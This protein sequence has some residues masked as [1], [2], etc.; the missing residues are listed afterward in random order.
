MADAVAQLPE[1]FVLDVAPPTGLPEGFILD[2]PVDGGTPEGFVVDTPVVEETERPGF[3]ERVSTDIEARQK[4]GDEI[5][6]F[7]ERGEQSYPETLLQLTGKVGVGGVLDTMGEA[8][9]S[10]VEG[11]SA[12]TP[13]IIEDPLID[14]VTETAQSFMET[15][16]GQAGLEAFEA[17][18]EAW[19]A[20]KAENPR[21]ARN[22]EAG[23]NI[24]LFAAP[25]KGKPKTGAKPTIAG[26]AGEVME[27]KAVAQTARQK[28]DFIDELV[29]PKPTAKVRREQVAR[30][31]EEGPLRTKKV[32]PSVAERVMADEVSLIEGV[33]A[34]ET[35]Q[36]NFN[37]IQK[38]VNDS[39][40]RLIARLKKNDV[41]IPRRE[42]ASALERV[43]ARLDDIP[44]L[45]GS[46]AETAT[47]VMDMA[48]KIVAKHPGT[49]SGLLKARKEFDRLVRKERGDKALD[50]ARDNAMSI[51][52]REVRQAMNDL[53]AAKVV[54]VP[55]KASLK[56]QSTLLRTMDNLEPKVADTATNSLKR[57]YQN[58]IDVVSLRGDFNQ[59]MAVFAGVGGLG[60]AAMFAPMFRE[61]LIAGGL[62]F[63][64]GKA[65]MSAT[66]KK[67]VA[68][69]LK[70]IDK[71]IRTTKDEALISKLR[72]D[73]AAVV[74][75][76]KNSVE[77]PT[78]KKIT[79]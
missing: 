38:E 44:L 43:S 19:G 56:K 8:F 60:A 26:R 37:I 71:A 79:E 1:G 62:V 16:L 33:G 66:A 28:A 24:G 55:V 49:A 47:R 57:A 29:M 3:I 77:K 18:V 23:V 25:V 52:T 51:A 65:V 2:A 7:Y 34:S 50:P 75:I 74:E 42:V 67:G 27:A 58:V 59:V 68:N 11:L 5:R 48:K 69:L 78:E 22:I 10:G 41:L 4:L 30:T 61:G 32:E 6:G 17:G 20:F 53:I 73:R 21:A 70:G 39:V 54:K 72:V 63:A 12:I 64:G 35:L 14:L 9:V 15:D 45:T 46:A 13:D 76:L 40:K 36:G 31:T